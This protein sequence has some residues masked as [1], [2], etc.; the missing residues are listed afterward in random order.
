MQ[1]DQ[2]EQKSQGE[3][4]NTDK[5]SDSEDMEVYSEAFTQRQTFCRYPDYLCFVHKPAE[6]FINPFSLV[7]SLMLDI[8]G[9]ETGQEDRPATI[10]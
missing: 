5:K 3:G 4:Q 2:G 1:V 6:T 8:R 9:W 7:V 10:E